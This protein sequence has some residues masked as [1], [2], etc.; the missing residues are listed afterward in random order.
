[1]ATAA[2][3]LKLLLDSGI[4]DSKGSML[5]DFHTVKVNLK[6]KSAIGYILQEWLAE[7]LTSQKI[8]FRVRDNTQ[9]WPDFLLDKNSDKKGILEIKTFDSD[10]SPNFDVANFDAYHRSLLDHSYRLDADYMVFAYTFN[11]GKL[12]V[13]EVFLRKVWEI[14]CPSKDWP[15]RVQCKQKVIANIRPANWFSERATYKPFT[16]KMQFLE[17]IHKT[18]LKYQENSP[19]AREWLDKVKENYRHHM[20]RPLA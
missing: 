14:T 19:Y 6:E 20:G 13:K 16:D 5:F 8:Y 15:I 9:L 3:I 7:W 4:K 18:L 11:D 17:A 2:G 12:R 10:A 1:M